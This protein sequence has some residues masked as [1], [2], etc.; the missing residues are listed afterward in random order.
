MFVCV[1]IIFIKNQIL[2]I[3][4]YVK[5]S[6]VLGVKVIENIANAKCYVKIIKSLQNKLSKL[7]VIYY[8]SNKLS[9]FNLM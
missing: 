6:V 8:K 3:A 5:L 4:F 2:R 7:K 9:K 1:K